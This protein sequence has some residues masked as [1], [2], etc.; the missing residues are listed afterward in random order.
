MNKTQYPTTSCLQE[1][2]IK[3]NGTH[4]MQGKVCKRISCKWKPKEGMSD[5]ANIRQIQ[6]KLESQK[7]KKGLCF[8]MNEIAQIL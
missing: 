6:I 3:S 8:E 7:G 2:H 1:S 4:K 5:H